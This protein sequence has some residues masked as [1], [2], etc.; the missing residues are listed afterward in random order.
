M[1]LFEDIK[2]VEEYMKQLLNKW[3]PESLNGD[4][5]INSVALY[6]NLKHFAINKVCIKVGSL[7]FDK[8]EFSFEY[9]SYVW[10]TIEIK[11]KTYILDI[12]QLYFDK[13]HKKHNKYSDAIY[14]EGRSGY[15]PIDRNEVAFLPVRE[16]IK[17]TGLEEEEKKENIN[18]EPIFRYNEEMVSYVMELLK[19]FEKNR[20]KAEA[21]SK[22]KLVG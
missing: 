21:E 22:I 13:E 11:N 12:S 2:S 14:I 20:K 18:A 17:L 6:T 3:N 15:Y 19:Y 4:C 10:N 8:S 5:C 7:K 1:Y 9:L 16:I